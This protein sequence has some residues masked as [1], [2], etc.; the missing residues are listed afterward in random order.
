MQ[1]E[2]R[3]LGTFK[4]D[5]SD[6]HITTK[7]ANAIRNLQQGNEFYKIPFPKINTGVKS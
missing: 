7:I 1:K 4:I 2:C 3:D 6:P 5:I